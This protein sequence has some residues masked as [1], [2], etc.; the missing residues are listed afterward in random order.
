MD[1][2]T[3]HVK[4]PDTDFTSNEKMVIIQGGRVRSTPVVDR[5]FT[6]E[7]SESREAPTPQ[8]SDREAPTPQYPDREAPTPQFRSLNSFPFRTS[9]GWLFKKITDYDKP[10]CEFKTVKFHNVL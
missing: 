6:E 1:G 3:L 5:Q 9:L 8:Y 4:Y 2:F 10:A 7:N